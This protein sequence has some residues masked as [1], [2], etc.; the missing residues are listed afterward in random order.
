LTASAGPAAPAGQPSSALAEVE[1]QEAL[2]L[3]YIGLLQQL[4]AT[5]RQEQILSNTIGFGI[6]QK[7]RGAA[8]GR[9]WVRGEG[10]AP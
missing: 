4:E 10:A 5:C 6:I 2:Q 3:Q 1:R 8:R 9:A 7:A